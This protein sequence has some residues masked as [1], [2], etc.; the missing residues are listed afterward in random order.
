MGES[1]VAKG[2][3]LSQFA[4]YFIKEV[5]ADKISS[6]YLYYSYL[7]HVVLSSWF[8]VPNT[9]SAPRV[10]LRAHQ[11]TAEDKEEL[12]SRFWPARS[13]TAACSASC[14]SHTD[15]VQVSHPNTPPCQAAGCAQGWVFASLYLILI[16]TH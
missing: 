6:V 3:E 10:L 1:K 9:L 11:I 15:R 2:K 5:T 8:Y 16:V 7:L 13:P 14:E 4:D 12:L